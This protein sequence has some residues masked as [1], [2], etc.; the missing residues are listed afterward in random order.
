M[1]TDS[2]TKKLAHKK[3]SVKDL[4]RFI[5][6]KSG[7]VSNFALLL[8][9]GCSITSGVRSA[10]ELS[11]VWSQEIYEGYE[12]N[13]KDDLGAIKDFFKQNHSD[14]YNPN[15][16]YSS[17]FEK[18]YDLPAQRRAFV[19]EEVAGKFPSLGYAYLIRLVE[20]RY[21]NTIFT[22]NF[23]DLINESFHLFADS[24]LS[25]D[26]NIRDSMRPIVCA[27]D[28]SVKSISVTS[29]RPKIIK[30]HGDFL[31]DDIKSTLRETE[32]LEEN[33]RNKF[34]EFCKEFGLIVVGY[35]GNDRSVMDV[36][37]YLLKSDDYLKNGLYW[38][39]KKEDHISDELH[40]LLW[41]DRVYYVEID[42]FDELFAELYE[43]LN[44][45]KRNLPL[46]QDLPNKNNIIIER[47]VNNS[48]LS[49]SPSDIIKEV[50]EKLQNEKKKNSFFSSVREVLF[51]EGKIDDFQGLS[52]DETFELFEI[53]RLRTAKRYDEAL[54]R[55]KSNIS[56]P[57]YSFSLKNRLKHIVANILKKQNKFEEALKYCDEIIAD[58]MNNPEEY[59][60]KNN[61]LK[62]YEDRIENLRECIKKHP[63]SSRIYEQIV[64]YETELLS[65]NFNDHTTLMT[66]LIEDLE[67]GIKCNPAM[68]NDC[69]SAKF[70]L[71]L[72]KRKVYSEEW[73]K[74]ALSIC[75]IAEAQNP[76]H[77]LVFDYKRQL[78]INDPHGNSDKKTEGLLEL[79]KESIPK[80]DNNFDIYI[81]MCLQL[82][83]KTIVSADKIDFIAKYIEQNENRLKG[84]I[85][86]VRMFADFYARRCGNITKALQLWSSVP[87]DDYDFEIL[88]SL[89][90]C[91]SILRKK[92]EFEAL[93]LRVKD[94]FNTKGQL[95]I[96]LMIAESQEDY[97]KALEV[98]KKLQADQA[99]E[100][101]FFTQEMYANLCLGNFEEVF[102]RSKDMLQ[103]I[104]SDEKRSFCDIINYEIA[105]KESGRKIRTDKLEY[106]V[107]SNASVPLKVASCILLNKTKE[108]KAFIEDDIRFDYSAVL[109]YLNMFVFK[110]YLDNETK[111]KLE[112]KLSE[113]V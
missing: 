97:V 62:K 99:Y 42:G 21:F 45:E 31:F 34:V 86:F 67:R 7:N 68:D 82:L 50:M 15:H 40:K 108:A 29:V 69:Y 2:L 94:N 89:K 39:V 112:E 100:Y 54:N 24:N 93:L 64:H 88:D 16:E 98:L 12:H 30:L 23:D 87:E 13:S 4:V 38:C 25:D 20:N 58:S 61:F 83:D 52:S 14:W 96:D 80:L 75:Q 56:N 17:L 111:K 79:W 77:P 76:E 37:N 53:E 107:N 11:K 110:K 36:I 8:G 60:F 91:Y 33:I 103:E 44:S 55:A 3:R 92:A 59:F 72:S 84:K 10:T 66:Q 105:R 74:E 18:R 104:T 95:R 27:H 73:Y 43:E 90:S 57:N 71:L 78:I 6:T 49:S 26:E 85:R 109:Q 51:P 5:K 101:E 106:I 28:S 19:E 41:K 1:K 47:L 65:R 9:A 48:S 63:C 35:A 32:S 46:P 81:G 113:I 102:N 22:T 70:S